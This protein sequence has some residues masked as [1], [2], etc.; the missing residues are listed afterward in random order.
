V[1]WFLWSVGTQVENYSIYL[2]I[3]QFQLLLCN[4]LCTVAYAC[5]SWKFFKERIEDEELA[6]INFFADEYISYQRRVPT[7]L[8]FI[9]G[10]RID[11]QNNDDCR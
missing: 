5:I 8:P 1:G 9:R 4:P 3:L 10:Y 2:F 6:L 7:G 11:V